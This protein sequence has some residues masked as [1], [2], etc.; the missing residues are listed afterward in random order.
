[1]GSGIHGFGQTIR[2]LE[3]RL[4]GS[5]WHVL[6]RVPVKPNESP[7]RQCGCLFRTLIF[8]RLGRLILCKAATPRRHDGTGPDLASTRS[9]CL[10]YKSHSPKWSV[11][12]DI[13]A[14][15][16]SIGNTSAWHTAGLQYRAARS[17]NHHPQTL[18]PGI[19]DALGLGVPTVRQAEVHVCTSDFTNV[20]RFSS[21]FR[22]PRRRTKR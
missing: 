18:N 17:T 7:G 11:Y 8:K 22:E 1:M 13:Y 12:M 3:T 10:R 21:G 19:R 15:P 5:A 6:G 9:T 16:Y 2:F 14:L 4:K 20:H